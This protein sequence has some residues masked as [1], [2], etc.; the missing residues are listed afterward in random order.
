MERE[1]VTVKVLCGS[2]SLWCWFTF[3]YNIGCKWPFHNEFSTFS[4][5][6][7]NWNCFSQSLLI[8]DTKIEISSDESELLQTSDDRYLQRRSFN[9]S[10]FHTSIN[11]CYLLNI[12]SRFINTQKVWW[13]TTYHPDQHMEYL[14]R[15]LKDSIKTLGSNKTEGGLRVGK[16][17]GTIVPILEQYEQISSIP[18]VS[19]A[20]RHLYHH[21]LT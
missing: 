11:S 15:I 14:N 19:D 6:Q 18:A 13:D 21:H 1:F 17:I 20:Q 5:K 12:Q 9:L 4:S 3:L 8:E 2:R 7:F 10:I 16:A